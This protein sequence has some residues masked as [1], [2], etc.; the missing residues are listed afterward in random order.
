MKQFYTIGYMTKP[1]NNRTRTVS[2]NSNT[3][4]SI[5]NNSINNNNNNNN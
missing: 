3:Y 1:K 5:N 4:N 2:Y